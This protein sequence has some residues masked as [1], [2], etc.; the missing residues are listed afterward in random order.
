MMTHA[1][2]ILAANSATEVIGVLSKPPG[3]STWERLQNQLA[4]LSKPCV[5][6]FSGLICAAGAS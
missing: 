3:P 6:H 2:E 1:L 5:V 4:Q